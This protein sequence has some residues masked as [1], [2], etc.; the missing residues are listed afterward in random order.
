MKIF[1]RNIIPIFILLFGS[2][3]AAQDVH[4]SQVHATPLFNN[5]AMTGLINGDVRGTAL[6]RNFSADQGVGY[7]TITGSADAK[8]VNVSG[9][10]DW[11]SGGL[12]FFQDKAGSLGLTTNSFDISLAYNAGLGGSGHFL[13]A[14]IQAGMQQKS[15]DLSQA[16]F[17]DQF[18][19][20]DFNPAMASSET[21]MNDQYWSPKIAA[22]LMYYYLASSRKYLFV[23]AS[24]FHLNESENSFTGVSMEQEKMKAHIIAGGSLPL[25]DQLDL[26][27]SFY[28][29]WQDVYSQ[30]NVGASLRFVMP[31]GTGA[32]GHSAITLGPY[33]RL[34]DIRNNLSAEA[35]IVAGR[36]EID[37]LTFG[38]SY[39]LSLTDL[40]NANSSAGA[41]ELSV[42]YEVNSGRNSS[43]G[44]RGGATSCPRF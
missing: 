4:F 13:S 40:Q 28:S 21:L 32:S 42:V 15:I 38:M 2:E 5:P 26:V 22:G 10:D 16:Q 20:T 39:D 41:L 3:L 7:R 23:G 19:G 31:G 34:S 12:S 14:G 24:A 44:S 17:G 25:S 6:Y 35:L 27:P 9:D 11:L 8:L 1:L 37:A 29:A 30:I 33:I 36:I 18:D 43:R